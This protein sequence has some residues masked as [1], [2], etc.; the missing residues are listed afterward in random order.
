MRCRKVTE[1]AS[2]SPKPESLSGG[3]AS[4]GTHP[5]QVTGT[6]TGTGQGSASTGRKINVEREVSWQDRCVQCSYTCTLSLV[7]K[8]HIVHSF[9][10]RIAGAK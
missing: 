3:G 7:G 5:P 1:T 4:G 9:M 10:G 2:K 8:F 6:E